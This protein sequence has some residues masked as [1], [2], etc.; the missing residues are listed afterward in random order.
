MEKTQAS[1]PSSALPD[2]SRRDFLRVGMAGIGAF[3]ASALGI[4]LI[5]YL[6]SPALKRLTPDWTQLGPLSDFTVGEPRQ[7]PF[8]RLRRDGWIERPENL[9]VWVW[10]KSETE[11]V[12]YNSHCTHLGCA[13]NWITQGQ[14]KGHFFSP[15]HDGVFALDG[16]V[17]SGPPPRPLDR[18]EAKIEDGQLYI[19]YQDFRLGIPEK[20][21]V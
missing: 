14:H 11:V 13:F 1:A 5:G 7:V 18:L 17:I 9:A 4:P 6:L 16:T 20:L 8:T 19:L 15:C 12:V 21:P 3:I 2:L 10:R